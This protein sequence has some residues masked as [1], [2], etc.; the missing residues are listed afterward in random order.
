MKTYTESE[1]Q[2]ILRL[3]RLWR[4]GKPG[5]T[6]ADLAGAYLADA[7]LARANLADAN[8]AGS[9]LAGAKTNNPDALIRALGILIIEG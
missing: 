7:N 2:E 3:H 1:L 6:R 5:G 4:Q 8:L 9:D